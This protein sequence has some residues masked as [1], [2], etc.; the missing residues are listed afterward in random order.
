MDV[1]LNSCPNAQ[2]NGPTVVSY[3][4]SDGQLTSTANVTFDV[5]AVDD[6]LSVAATPPDVAFDD[7][8][9]GEPA[10]GWIFHR[11]RWRRS[12]L[13]G[14]GSSDWIVDSSRIRW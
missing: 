7:G 2:F 11:S 6:P 14:D 12:D 5:S 4:I 8:D 1:L 10:N 3:Q 13:F 9:T